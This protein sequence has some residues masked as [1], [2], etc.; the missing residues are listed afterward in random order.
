MKKSAIG[1]EQ[2]P[3]RGRYTDNVIAMSKISKAKQ[4][5]E[6]TVFRLNRDGSKYVV[7]WD[8]LNSLRYEPA[9]FIRK[10]KMPRIKSGE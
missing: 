1:V 6:C 2:F 8:G 7:K 5:R 3:F 10:V 4:K 9:K